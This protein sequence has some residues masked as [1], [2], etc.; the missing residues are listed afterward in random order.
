MLVFDWCD[1]FTSYTG[2]PDAFWTLSKA[3]KSQYNPLVRDYPYL[4]STGTVV[5]VIS[6][7]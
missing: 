1:A 2:C 5:P 6:A 4:T 3:L 7:K